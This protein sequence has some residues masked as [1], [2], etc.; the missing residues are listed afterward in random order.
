MKL[1]MKVLIILASMWALVSCV[2]FFYSKHTLT[3]EY[4]KLEIKEVADD[5]ERTTRTLKSLFSS[6]KAL[7]FDWSQWDDAYRFMANKNQAFINSNLSYTTFVN[8][9]FNLIMFF[10]TQGKLFYGLNYDLE[11][12]QFVPI[13][14]SLLALL[15]QEKKF[16]KQRDAHSGKS[17]LL[18]WDN[19]Y[20]VLSALP[21]LNSEGKGDIRGTLVMGFFMNK[22]HIARL[23]DIVKMQVH[24]D[25][26][27]IAKNNN[28][29][30]S[31]YDYLRATN[32]DNY[33]KIIDDNHI[34][35]YTFIRDVD[36]NPIGI[37]S[38]TESRPVYQEGIRTIQKYLTIVIG[39]GIF[40]LISIWYLLKVFVLDRMI[41]ASNQVVD[42]TSNSTFHKRIEVS[43]NDELNAMIGAMNSLIEIIAIT[44]E[45][46]KKRISLRTEE[47]ERLSMLNK[48]LFAEMSN[49]KQIEVK[50]REGEKRLQHMAYYDALTGLP[51]RLY[52]NDIAQKLLEKAEVLHS[53]LAILFIDVDKFKSINDTYGHDVGDLYLRHIAEQLKI[54][55]KETD[56]AAR[57]SGDEFLVCLNDTIDKNN[58]TM[59]VNRLLQNLSTVLRT[60][61]ADISSTFSIGISIHP[62]DGKSV[63]ELEKHADLAMYF[64]KK[65]PNSA[66]Y[67]YND[68]RKEEMLD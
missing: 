20:V 38:I 21:I 55:I 24:L 16:T 47:L 48:N 6:L 66:F 11:T 40:F 1:R 22:E 36:N 19:Q 31:V 61:N 34:V 8:S 37:I 64:A 53:G 63:A 26:L 45:K 18:Q 60:E 7:T 33:I 32:K 54:S 28:Q 17:G 29:L 12:N 68:I 46:L 5:L 59:T 2:T 57:L 13:P 42:I 35:G 30:L 14:S 39:L 15:D 23:S 25:T 43:G 67:F 52:F 41:D 62:T 10:D 56:I 51:N 49:Q 50:L 44:E 65:Q 3:Q 4:T 27:P 9:K 58:L